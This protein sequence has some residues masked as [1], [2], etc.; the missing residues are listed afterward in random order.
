M[1][2]GGSVR[3]NRSC[4]INADE[5]AFEIEGFHPETP[6]KKK[7]RDLDCIGTGTLEIVEQNSEGP[8]PPQFTHSTAQ[9]S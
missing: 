7:L 9:D 3:V 2:Q 4:I 6:R 5:M 8:P 1:A